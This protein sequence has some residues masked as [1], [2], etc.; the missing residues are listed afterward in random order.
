MFRTFTRLLIGSIFIIF[1]LLFIL[2]SEFATF[3]GNGWMGFALF[4]LAI[5]LAVLGLKLDQRL[6]C[7]RLNYKANAENEK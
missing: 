7:K 5:L 2:L 4:F 1:F 3:N 6:K